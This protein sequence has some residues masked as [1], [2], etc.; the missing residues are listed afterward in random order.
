[1]FIQYTTPMQMAIFDTGQMAG[2]KIHMTSFLK[3]KRVSKYICLRPKLPILK[4]WGKPFTF[5]CPMFCFLRSFKTV[6]Q[7][8]CASGASPHPTN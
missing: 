8:N 6:T 2:Q 3:E 7:L 4:I 5:Q 1:M